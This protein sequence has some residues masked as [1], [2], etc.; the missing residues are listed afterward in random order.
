MLVRQEITVG[1][2]FYIES[3]GERPSHPSIWECEDAKM[4]EG[5]LFL[6]QFFSFCLFGSYS[7]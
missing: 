1:N 2:L 7:C 6:L 3:R 4:Q 5:P